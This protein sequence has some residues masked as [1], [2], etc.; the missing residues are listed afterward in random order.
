[1][2]TPETEGLNILELSNSIPFKYKLMPIKSRRFAKDVDRIAK[3]VNATNVI[4]SSK[5]R[6]DLDDIAL[7]NILSNLLVANEKGKYVAYSRNR[8]TYSK[9]HKMYGFEYFRYDRYIRIFDGLILI[10]LVIDWP[11]FYDHAKGSGM[12]SRMKLTPEFKK[13]FDDNQRH[14]QAPDIDFFYVNQKEEVRYLADN[15]LVKTTNV[16]PLI[17][18]ILKDKNKKAISYLPDKK[19]KD[20]L[21]RLKEYNQLMDLTSIVLPVKQDVVKPKSGKYNPK[22]EVSILVKSQDRYAI[23]QDDTSVEEAFRVLRSMAAFSEYKYLDA[24]DLDSN[25]SPTTETELRLSTVNTNTGMTTNTDTGRS[26]T[27]NAA[28]DYVAHNPQYQ[29][30]ATITKTI[31]HKIFYCKPLQCKL[32]RVFNN[33]KFDQGGRFYGAEYQRL[34]DEKRGTILIG[35]KEVIEADYSAFHVRMLYH[36]EGIDYQGDPYDLFQSDKVMRLFVKILT[37]I[38]I[39][40][41]TKATSIGA[42]RKLLDKPQNIEMKNEFE[43][44]KVKAGSIYD[45]ISSTH[46]DINKYLGTGY[47]IHLQFMDSEIAADVLTYFTSKNIPCLCVHDSFIVTRNHRN[48]LVDVMK[49]FYKKRFHFDPIITFK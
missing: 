45:L 32:Y 21:T 2:G 20:M 23:R 43:N 34:P 24:D 47:G 4:A 40:S 28:I 25:R 42:F 8:T 37:N 36:M 38:A 33:G 39:N 30:L 17:A 3:Y 41:Q 26:T 46:K 27:K 14:F 16:F 29:P 31:S 11:G 35:G 9:I 13:I 44:R 22:I 7:K 5:R 19:V 49:Y 18:V 10:G 15:S 1:M 48:E 6:R 12:N